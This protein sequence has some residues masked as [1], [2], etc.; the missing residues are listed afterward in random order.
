MVL[1]VGLALE[2]ANSLQKVADFFRPTTIGGSA[3][4]PLLCVLNR[5]TKTR[6]YNR[7]SRKCGRENIA[8]DEAYQEAEQRIEAAR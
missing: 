1:P 7:G 2:P 8:R 3:I 6:G 5:F 4:L